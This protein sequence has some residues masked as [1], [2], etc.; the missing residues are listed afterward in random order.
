MLT[1]FDEKWAITRSPWGELDKVE[2]I[3]RLCQKD[4][5]VQRLIQRVHDDVLRLGSETWAQHWAYS[6]ELCP[7]LFEAG[8][9]QLHVTVVFRWSI[10]YRERGAEAFKLLDCMPQN[11]KAQMRNPGQ[12]RAD[13]C[14][15]MLYYVQCPKVGMVF[16]D[17]NFKPFEH[18]QVKDRWLNQFLQSK[19]MNFDDACQERG[20]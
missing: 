3:A 18:F 20:P 8:R 13:T 16:N 17:G 5:Y 11:V 19:K 14:E 2:R 6:L 4:T 1:Y 7:K 15:P 10:Q 12:K 9:L